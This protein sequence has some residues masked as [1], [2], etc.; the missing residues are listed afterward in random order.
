MRKAPAM[1]QRE[2]V[3]LSLILRPAP[4]RPKSR[5]VYRDDWRR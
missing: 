3:M 2:L 1:S 4:R 5:L